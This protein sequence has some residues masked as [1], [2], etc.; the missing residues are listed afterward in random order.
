M[1]KTPKIV[2]LDTGALVHWGTG[3]ETPNPPG[4]HSLM[5]YFF[6]EFILCYMDSFK[7][8]GAC[9]WHVVVSLCFWW[10]FGGTWWHTQ[11]VPPTFGEYFTVFLIS[12]KSQ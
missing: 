7:T 4:N 5:L 2:P 8:V 3:P 1:P 9:C 10:H 6:M 12:I 11:T